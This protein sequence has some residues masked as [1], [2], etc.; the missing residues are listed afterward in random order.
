MKK[1][2]TILAGVAFIASLSSCK[3]C[4]E[5]KAEP[6]ATGGVSAKGE[7]CGNKNERAT[8]ESDWMKKYPTTTHKD[9]KCSD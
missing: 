9:V 4:V 8:F 1:L 3:K 6:I 7:N 2:L 5:C